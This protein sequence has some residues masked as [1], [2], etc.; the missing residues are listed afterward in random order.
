[1]SRLF[2]SIRAWDGGGRISSIGAHP[3]SRLVFELT[4]TNA[5]DQA[6]EH[7]V[8]WLAPKTRVGIPPTAERGA[9]F[10][11]SDQYGA[12]PCRAVRIDAQDGCVWSARL[13]EADNEGR[14]WIVELYVEH[15][16]G[17]MARF[18]AQLIC[19]NRS[20]EPFSVSRP[21]VVR[22][23]LSELSAEADGWALT[24]AAQDVFDADA[25]ISLLYDENRRLPVVVSAPHPD[26]G[27]SAVDMGT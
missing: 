12:N 18:G 6:I 22:D 16:I 10:D 7:C 2:E 4:D 5:F 9:P 21:S 25:L 3:V 27:I 24:E 19:V 26:N 17:R 13:D 8:H 11:L 20:T 1:M 14:T 23:I 15:W